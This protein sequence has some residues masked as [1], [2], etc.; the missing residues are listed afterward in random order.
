MTWTNQRLW[1]I[2]ER[3]MTDEMEHSEDVSVR[4][5]AHNKAHW[6]SGWRMRNNLW[7]NVS[8]WPG[9]SQGSSVCILPCRRDEG[10]SYS[11]L[12]S[13]WT[14]ACQTKWTQACSHTHT[15]MHKHR[16]THL[17]MKQK[18]KGGE[19]GTE[20]DRAGD[21]CSLSF[22]TASQDILLDVDKPR[23]R[24]TGKSFK[25]QLWL[26]E[27]LVKNS[28]PQWRDWRE[29]DRKGLNNFSFNTHLLVLE[30]DCLLSTARVQ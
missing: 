7:G 21:L 28:F 22:T 16:H 25:K 8:D 15:H 20:R 29:G 4:A 17:H 18:L 5:I 12:S 19:R 2:H 13:S 1:W 3:E 14:K 11:D 6:Y 23:T 26:P 27:E 9:K 30:T 24:D 10:G